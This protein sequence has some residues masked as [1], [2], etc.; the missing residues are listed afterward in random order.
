MFRILVFSCL[1]RMCCYMSACFCI[2]ASVYCIVSIFAMLEFSN[3]M[4]HVCMLSQSHILAMSYFSLFCICHVCL[5][6]Q[7]YI[8]YQRPCLILL[9]KSCAS[10]TSIKLSQQRTPTAGC[11]R[12]FFDVEFE[13]ESEFAIGNETEIEIK[14]DMKIRIEIEIEIEIDDRHR[15]R[16]RNR[17]EIETEQ[18]SPAAEPSRAARSRSKSSGHHRPPGQPHREPNV[19]VLFICLLKPYKL[20]DLREQHNQIWSDIS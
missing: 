19:C 15:D 3:S 18:A 7:F 9:W 14:L 11:E 17:A 5:F 1:S 4:F 6:S 20:L 8:C 16:N 2:F 13:T 12:S 10:Q